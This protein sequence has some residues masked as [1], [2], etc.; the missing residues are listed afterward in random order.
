MIC[1]VIVMRCGK[2]CTKAETDAWWRTA[3]CDGLVGNHL[4]DRKPE[5]ETRPSGP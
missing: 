2:R 4:P 5:R 1:H 3:E